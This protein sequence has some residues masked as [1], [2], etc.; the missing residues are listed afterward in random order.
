MIFEAEDEW[1]L[2]GLESTFSNCLD[3]LFG[4]EVVDHRVPMSDVGLLLAI[5]KI[6]FN[7]SKDR[8]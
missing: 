1:V 6:K 3:D 4:R 7:A 2:A 8:R 5:P